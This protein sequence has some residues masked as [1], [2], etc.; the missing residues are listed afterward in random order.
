MLKK[1]GLIFILFIFV[2][3][4]LLYGCTDT[5]P[6]VIETTPIET[7][8]PT[9][10][11]IVMEDNAN[12][13]ITNGDFSQ[14]Y[15]A[16]GLYTEGT[17]CE[18]GPSNGSAFIPIKGTGN[19][20]WG[21][22][23][24]QDGIL[25]T[26]DCTYTLKFDIKSEVERTAKVRVQLNASPYT[27]YIEEVIT[28]P[29]G[30][31]F[32]TYEFDFTMEQFTDPAGRLVFNLGKFEGE[33]LE[34]H[35]V[36]ID[37]VSLVITS[38]EQATFDLGEREINNIKINQIGYMPENRK[39][40]L[41]SDISDADEFR[42]VSSDGAVVYTGTMSDA[43]DNPASGES[44]RIADFSEVTAEGT[45]HIEI[46]NH[47][48]SYDF[49]ISE[50]VYSDVSAAVLKMFYYQRCGMELTEDYIGDFAH[51]ACHTTEAIVFGTEDKFQDVSGGWHDAGDF[52]RYVTPA[53]KA[54]IDL[55]LAY[56]R[57]PESFT[58][59]TD[60]PE[61]GNG[62]ADI[63]DEAKYEIDFLLKMQDAETGGVY[64]KVTTKIFSG[65]SMPDESTEQLI[66][67]PISAEATADFAA[68]MAKASLVYSQIDAA[69]SAE[70]L[71]K[72][73]LAWQW[74]AAN[75]NEQKFSN[76]SGIETGE[77]GD[78]N[79]MD[80]RFWA[81]AELYKATGKA[82]YH[83][84]LKSG[85]I[86]KG[87]GWKDMGYYGLISYLSLPENMRDA[88]LYDEMLAFLL[89]DAD[90]LLELTA[91][92]AY[93]ISLA[94]DDYVWG[95]NMVVANNAML[96]LIANDYSPNPAYV[97]AAY[98]H[99]NYLLG[100][101]ALGLSYITGFGTNQVYNPHHRVTQTVLKVFEGLVIGGPNAN[102]DDPYASVLLEGQPPA[103]CYAD[104][105]QSY[106]T[107]EIT[108]Y[109]NSPVVY[110]LTYFE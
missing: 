53:S 54:V 12:E 100:K 22:Q 29:A 90:G 15:H 106:S 60:I 96:L 14:G 85:K 93:E 98:E 82:E 66:L 31:E 104:S 68:V 65:V 108:I 6:E 80:E 83:D 94:D 79:S 57:S 3:F 101:N 1:K 23:M 74:L 52:G 18:F 26:R 39:V 32:T 11:P 8:A 5:K 42:V 21:V 7:A 102:L 20:E 99:L 33:E 78:F 105:D 73:E 62:I 75:P 10:A 63:L 76:P 35:D 70:C 50:N 48:N 40:A 86:R 43:K 51:G 16:W 95:S 55:L 59:D 38:G 81:A 37:N 25:L 92:E 71:N 45:Y 9:E 24:F 2:F 77:Y 91:E 72:A 107:N 4:N 19:V 41:I 17:G 30:D 58:D 89:D 27:G 67:S 49:V 84:F 47:D 109:W 36:E 56:E 110:L 13:I 103:K 64:H 69:F 34:A 44:T 88:E 97:T 46:D 61:H 28:I 87:L